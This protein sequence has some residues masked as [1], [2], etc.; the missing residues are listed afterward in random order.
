MAKRTQ[1]KYVN[2]ECTSCKRINYKVHK[3][4]KNVK[5]RLELKR[6]CR[7]CKK[8]TVYKETK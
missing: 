5:E 2:L 3:N 7:H 1:D 4:K 6:Y 8:H